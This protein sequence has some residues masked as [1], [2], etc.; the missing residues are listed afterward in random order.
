MTSSVRAAV[1]ILHIVEKASILSSLLVFAMNSERRP[2][3]V[4]SLCFNMR[5]GR[6]KCRGRDTSFLVRNL[7]SSDS[8]N[9]LRTSPGRSEGG[10]FSIGNPSTVP[11]DGISWGH[12][13]VWERTVLCCVSCEDLTGISKGSPCCA[14]ETV[15]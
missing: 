6:K 15:D 2:I 7:S 4:V 9:S 11:V 1:N 8:L 5:L 10:K 14:A 12:G 3:L 13:H